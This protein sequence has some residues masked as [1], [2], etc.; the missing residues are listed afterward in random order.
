[1]GHIQKEILGTYWTHISTQVAQLII[2]LGP[3][4][5]AKLYIER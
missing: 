1:M 2:T 3:N 4:L 5:T